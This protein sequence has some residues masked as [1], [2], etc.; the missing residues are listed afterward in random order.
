MRIIFAGSPAIA[1][2]C[3]ESLAVLALESAGGAASGSGGSADGEAGGSTDGPA[4]GKTR[5][6]AG[7][8]AG[9]LDDSTGDFPGG[10]E[11]AGLLTNPDSPRGRHGRPEPT[12]LAA[13][14]AAL[15]PRFREAGLKAPVIMKP[16]KLG[17]RAR[18]EAAA[19]EP[20]LL[21]SFAYGKIFGPK[22]LGLFPLGGLNIHPSL[23]PA[24]RGP[25][26]IPQAILNR[27]RETGITVQ[28][29]A[30]EMDRGDILAQESFPLGG[31]ETAASLGAEMARRAA[32]LL[33]QA[34][35]ALARGTAAARPQDNGGASYCRLL[36]REDGRIIW[37]KGALDIEAQIRAFTPW[38]LSWTLDQGRPLY[39]L[40]ASVSAGGPEPGG[41]AAPGTVLGVDRKRGI[42]IQTGDG[43][44]AVSLLQYSTKKALDWRAFLNGV[45]D[46][47]GRRLG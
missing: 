35:R 29:L 40:A 26:P 7:G 8:P 11:L 3:L 39:I 43:V 45:R 41:E 36:S 19:L 37:D 1:V 2:P 46:F 47:S 30:L 16:E 33:P 23:L 10:L 21:V 34:L 12:E 4:N 18:R 17:P 25:A 28:R 6:E 24:Y 44:L 31:A 15:A 27:D 5:G 22:F 42:L 14:A 9:D 38:P 32:R 20:D 13:A